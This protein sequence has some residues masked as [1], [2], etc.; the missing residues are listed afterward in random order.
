[1]SSKSVG[2]GHPKCF[3]DGKVR[4]TQRNVWDPRVPEETKKKYCPGVT[5]A[6]G[7][8]TRVAVKVHSP[9]AISIC[10]KK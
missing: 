2:S 5:K 10:K 7:P 6:Q 9:K 8:C 4:F 3:G 1:M